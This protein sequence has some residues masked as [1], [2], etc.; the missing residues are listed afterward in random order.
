MQQCP[1]PALAGVAPGDDLKL[2]LQR[3]RTDASGPAAPASGELL[4]LQHVVAT[5][6]QV[7]IQRRT[8]LRVDSRSAAF[9]GMKKRIIVVTRPAR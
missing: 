9:I 3:R 6:E 7:R 2:R 5:C 4:Q 1:R 8:R